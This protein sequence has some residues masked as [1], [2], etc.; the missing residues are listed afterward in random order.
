[1]SIG[2]KC[3]KC[4]WMKEYT[5]NTCVDELPTKCPV[6]GGRVQAYAIA[7]WMRDMHPDL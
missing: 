2:L 7:H 1:M 6:C 5:D 4:G 3:S